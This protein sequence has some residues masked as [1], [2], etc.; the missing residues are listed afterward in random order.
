[1]LR[2]IVDEAKA[3]NCSPI[4]VVIGGGAEEIARELN[5]VDVV[6]N[7]NWKRGIGTSI[8][9]G[10]QD[11]IDNASDIEAV[12]L[13][14]CDQP[15]VD[16]TTI[17]DLLELFETTKKPIVASGYE[18]TVG[19][20]ALFDRSCFE[21][22]LALDDGSGAKQVI[23]SNRERVAEFPFPKGSIDIDTT[24]DWK[25]LAAARA[26]PPGEPTDGSASRPY[27]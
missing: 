4:V 19:V 20:P 26:R 23:L 24:E 3:A 13:M 21:E 7:K 18:N 1:M 2:R 15:F 22:L 12:V 5:G 8:R 10:I 17:R 14:V 9:A 25:R 27:H 6:E 16:A 11:L